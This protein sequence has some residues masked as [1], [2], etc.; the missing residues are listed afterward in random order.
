MWINNTDHNVNQVAF[1]PCFVFTVKVFMFGN[2]QKFAIFWSDS[3]KLT[4]VSWSVIHD[5]CE[6]L[7][8]SVYSGYELKYKKWGYSYS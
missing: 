1:T 5:N 6:N 2:L 8:L 4:N 7:I 3:R